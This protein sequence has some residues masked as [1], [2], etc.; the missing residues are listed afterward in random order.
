MVSADLLQA[1]VKINT[2]HILTA[3][4]DRDILLLLCSA[5]RQT[6]TYT[7]TPR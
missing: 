1:K 4:I 5:K 3:Y 6:Y 2:I 7:R